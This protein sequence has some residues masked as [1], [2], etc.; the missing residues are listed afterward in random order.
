MKKILTILTFLATIINSFSQEL[1]TEYRAYIEKY[2][3]GPVLN[4]QDSLYLLNIPEKTMPQHLR[5]TTL[6]P[7]VDNSTTPYLRPVFGQVGASCGQAAMVGYN[8][9]YEMAYR[10]DQPAFFPQTQYPTHFCWNFQNGGD[11][12]YGVS[13]FHSIEILR[14]CGTMN[15]AD[16]G[17]YYDDGQRWINGYD[18]Y[19]NGMYNRVKGVYSI[20]T[21][22]AEGLESLKHWLYDHMGE[23]SYGGVASYYAN[24][25][26]NA[27][28]LNDTTPEGGKHVMTAWFPAA[29]HAMTIIGYND[30]IRWDYNSDGQ[31]T[32]TIDINFDEMVDLRDW[33]IGGVKF[34]NSHG[35]Q[36]Q[37]SGF[38]YMTYKCLAETFENGGIWNQSVH[39]LDIDENY[40]PLITYK[41]TL[42][43]NYRGKIKILAGVSADT[44]DIAPEWLMDFP[45]IDYQGANYS[46]Q[47]AG[48]EE[49]LKSLEFGLDITP[50]LSHLEPGEPARFFFIID[51]NDPYDDGQGEITSFSVMDY[52]AGRQEI[53]SPQTPLI[54][55]NNSRSIVSVIH[56]PDFEMVEIINESCPAFSVNQPYSLQME[57][58][59]G[60]V[61]YTWDAVYNY[62]VA[63]SNDT[64]PATQGNQVLFTA[65]TDTIMPV[66]LGFSFPFYGDVYDTVFMHINGH[67]QF[68]MAQLPWPYMTEPALHFRSNRMITPMTNK[69][70]TIAP[71]DG[72]GGWIAI[73]DSSVTFKWKLSWVT[74]PG[75]TDFNFAVR[76]HQ[77]GNI[78]FIYGPSTLV[79]IPW[80]GGISAG[81]K[82]DYIDA[83][84]SGSDHIEA[85]KKI[86]FY[87]RPLPQQL[88][89]SENG[90]L[91]G[92]FDNDNYIYD[93]SFRVTDRS[94]ISDIKTLQ[95]SSGPLLAF[96]VH[97]GGD[98]RIE[99]GDT[100]YL[101]VN[102]GNNGTDTLINTLIQLA[103]NDTYVSISDPSCAAGTLLPGQVITIP[104]AFTFIVSWE[105]PDRYDLFFNVALLVDEG[106][107]E[108]E[109]LL[110]ADAPVLK[111]NK[112][113]IN[114]SDGR[115]DPGETAPLQ[116]TYQNTG[117]TAIDS[118]TVELIS[119]APEVHILEDPV[120][121][122]GTI[123]KGGSVTRSYLL[124]AEESTPMGMTA[125]FTLSVTALPGL[126]QQDSI[127]LKIGKTPVLIIDMD[128]NQHSGPVILSMLEELNVPATYEY[129]V[130]P[131]ISDNYS[132]FV[133][134]GYHTS[135]HELTLG[136]AQKLADFLDDGGKIYMEGRKTWHEDPGT[137]LQP[138]FSLT[139]V[140]EVTIFDTITGIDGT[141]TQGF[142]LLNDAY[143]Y[144]SYYYLVPVEPA[145]SIHQD[146]NILHSCAVAYDAGTYRTIGSLFELGTM[147]GL[148][149]HTTTELLKEY[150]EFF[151]IEVDPVGIKEDLPEA[152]EWVVYPNPA[153]C[154]LIIASTL[155][156]AK[157]TG[158]ISG[159][160]ADSSKQPVIF[161][162]VDVFGNR[163]AE[164]NKIEVLPYTIDISGLSPGLYFIRLM[165]KDGFSYT[166]KILKV[167]H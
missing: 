119:L 163:V 111:I 151:G 72:D 115:L 160:R 74:N 49:Y 50:L 92:L 1:P 137:P 20:N 132:I 61:P 69:S 60:S 161:S 30:S 23:G 98:S 18:V 59:G 27:N 2:P 148:P 99:Y 120:Q 25:P 150:L 38:C 158:G 58:A 136:E 64:F 164:C 153:C 155:N 84:L 12:W 26:W 109:L 87:Y 57:A 31:Y 130:P 52:T 33:E 21:S 10:R 88:E 79:D 121:A 105:A 13:Y 36:A 44:S 40:Q 55:E 51:E 3:E 71:A 128:P 139:T 56:T 22:T 73:N 116:V 114:D 47:G 152:G 24:T 14:L 167:S 29:S 28:Y 110:R 106:D 42:K 117:H 39:I 104:S 146:N 54:L 7:I 96:T 45:I 101:D 135:N 100:V 89:L 16:Y 129:R 85:G 93:L 166:E 144:F 11:G 5:S 77:N 62:R 90:L 127:K 46:L 63:Q 154:Q 147:T 32:N 70:F 157:P 78:E 108:G 82:S 76:L 35:I 94:G 34:V 97:A 113:F 125:D 83:P 156:S 143:M 86:S 142:N 149:P 126:Q 145:F 140:W 122:Y 6:P 162:I 41:V 37:D 165:D 95:L 75:T 80:L 141:F 67:L 19:Y 112:Y 103:S 9:T 81:N 159:I 102:I 53:I 17:D 43:H 133:C 15:S 4:H 134:L 124:M 66:A 48:T 131:K 68:D 138:K 91:T 118:V 107:W 8:F 65:A 123:G